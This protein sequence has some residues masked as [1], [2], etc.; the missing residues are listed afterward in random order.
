MTIRIEKGWDIRHATQVAT[1]YEEAFGAKFQ[2]AIPD[3]KQRILVLSKS[4]VTEFSFVAY[5]DDKIV[6]LSGFNV[7]E[8]SL[9]GGIGAKGLIHQ[10]GLFAGLWASAVFSLFERTPK[11]GELVMDGIAVDSDY[12][13]QGIGSQ[14]LDQIILHAQDNG[15][16][17]VRLD[18]IDSNPR[19][20]KLYESKGFVATKVESFPY[21]KWLVGFSGSTTMILDLSTLK[22]LAKAINSAAGAVSQTRLAN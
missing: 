17:S 1:L 16:N 7:R 22:S 2:R 14:L 10:L 4:F 6:G 3:K 11:K 12:R 9:T 21:L 18:V 15:F 8:G 5:S 20:K 19:A 13:G